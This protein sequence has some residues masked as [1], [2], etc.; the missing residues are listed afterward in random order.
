MN[1]SSQKS[2]KHL[3]VALEQARMSLKLPQGMANWNTVKELVCFF[4]REECEA[5]VIENDPLYAKATKNWERLQA[6]TKFWFEALSDIF[7]KFFPSVQ[8]GSR[9]NMLECF[10]AEFA[11]RRQQKSSSLLVV[12]PVEPS[13]GQ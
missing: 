8:P 3:R 1:S 12:E 7:P 4:D 9:A 5:R 6:K 2:H 10:V 13:T 11:K